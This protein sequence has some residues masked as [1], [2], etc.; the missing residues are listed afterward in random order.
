M[1]ENERKESTNMSYVIGLRAVEHLLSL[2]NI[3]ISYI[4][5][6]NCK[7]IIIEIK[8][9]IMYNMNFLNKNHRNKRSYNY[10]ISIS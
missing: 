6:M 5:M 3:K 2:N 9:N 10:Y 7:Y 1:F 8:I 4:I